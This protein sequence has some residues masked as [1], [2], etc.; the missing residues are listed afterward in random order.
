[1][2]YALKI[3]SI[4]RYDYESVINGTMS[5]EEFMINTSEQMDKKLYFI[6]ARRCSYSGMI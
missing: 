4:S 6:K 1:M 2:V 3:I 5:S